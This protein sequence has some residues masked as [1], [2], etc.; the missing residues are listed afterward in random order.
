MAMI[1]FS[2]TEKVGAKLESPQNQRLLK[3]VTLTK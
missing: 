2:K 3:I 1:V